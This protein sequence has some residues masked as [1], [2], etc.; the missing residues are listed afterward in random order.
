MRVPKEEAAAEPTSLT[1]DAIRSR[2]N[3]DSRDELKPMLTRR[4]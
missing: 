1:R 2:F 3:L 4:V